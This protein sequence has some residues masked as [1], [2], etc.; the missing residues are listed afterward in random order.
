MIP[1]NSNTH[2]FLQGKVILITGATS[3]IGEVTAQALAGMGATLVFVGRNPGRSEATLDKIRQVSRNHKVEYIL[4]DLSVTA[5]VQNLADQFL[6]SYD[7]LDVLINNAGAEFFTRQISADGIE[8]T[9]ALN[10]LSYFLL[11]NLLIE[12]MKATAKHVGEARVVNVASDAHYSG[13]MR[14]DDLMFERGY[15]P[16][17]FRAYAQSKLANVLFT[18][19]LSRRLE[20]SGVT[21][22]ALHPGFVATNLGK[23]NGWLGRLA[24]GIAHRF[25]ISPLEGAK[26]SIFLAS[27]PE[28]SGVTGEFFIKNKPAQ[29]NPDAYNLENAARLWRISERLTSGST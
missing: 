2:Q 11:T 23:N 13:K 27:S 18:F 25:A 19:E 8:M 28:V 15:E 22:N 7:R 3:G 6:Q 21:A 14:F 16:G 5:Q 1:S 29:A 20:G 10:H 4:A 9:F 26:T 17:G 24:M 12:T